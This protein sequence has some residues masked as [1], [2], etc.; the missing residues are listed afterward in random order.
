MVTVGEK[1]GELENMLKNISE[2]L[3][4]ST[5]IVVERISRGS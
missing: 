3:E 1:S 5:D 2:G 4:E